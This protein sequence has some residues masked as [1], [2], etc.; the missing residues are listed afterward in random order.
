M[1]YKTGMYGGAF[2]P[3]HLGTST[4]SSGPQTGNSTANNEN[5]FRIPAGW[6]AKPLAESIWSGSTALRH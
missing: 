5:P 6:I 4:I 3:L 2:D 1:R